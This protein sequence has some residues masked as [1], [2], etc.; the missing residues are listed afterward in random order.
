MLHALG[1]LGRG[2]EHV[3]H[4]DGGG[5]NGGHDAVGE[6]VG[7]RFLAQH[8]HN[9]FLGRYIAAGGTAQ[10][11][12]EGTGGDVNLAEEAAMLVCTTTAST[13]YARSMRFVKVYQG[14][15]FL[16]K[17]MNL[18]E[19]GYNT[20]HRE[21]TVRRDEDGAGAVGL[22]LLQLG[23]KVCHIVVGVAVAGSLAQ[24]HAV[25]DGGVV[26]GVGHDGVLLSE[27]SLKET[28]VGIEAGAE[29][30]GVFGTQEVAETLFELPVQGLSTADETH[31]GHTE[32]PAVDSLFGGFLK[33][34][35]V[36]KA[37]VVVGAH[38]DD[39]AAIL[40]AYL[41][42]L[43]RGDVALLLVQAGLFQ[44]GEVCNQS[45]FEICIVHNA[46]VPVSGRGIVILWLSF[47]NDYAMVN[48]K[49][50]NVEIYNFCIIHRPEC[51]AIDQ[52]NSPPSGVSRRHLTFQFVIRI[53]YL[54]MGS[55]RVF[56]GPQ[57][58][59]QRA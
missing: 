16:G 23:L 13:Q 22:G 30:D 6:E 1:K 31:G 17:L 32:A 36:G 53:S 47:V 45:V 49:M 12:T 10:R 8:V 14:T 34:G 29:E 41:R 39:F 19:A 43:G 26:E 57:F 15:V 18:V 54:Q 58:V 51:S 7:A 3:N 38:V 55:W 5:G 20:V 21:Y 59:N 42:E 44:R 50:L 33:L 4:L 56:R 35:V 48:S 2:L 27:Q 25:D 46:H 11:L 52:P 37:Q 40:K 24:A 28:T 9:L